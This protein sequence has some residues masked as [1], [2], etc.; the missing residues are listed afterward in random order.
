[1]SASAARFV[2]VTLWTLSLAL[3]AA[4]LVF[5]V[6][7][8]RDPS[9][10]L[11]VFGFATVGLLLASRRPDNAIGWIFSAVGFGIALGWLAAEYAARAL[12]ERPGSLPGGLWLVWLSEAVLTPTF[13]LASVL[14]LLLF[15]DG[16]PPSP[17]WRVA[18]WAAILI[19]VAFTVGIAFRPGEFFSEPFTSFENPIG[20]HLG[21]LFEALAEALWA[22]NLIGLVV[23][24]ASQIVRFRRAGPEQRAQIKWVTTV[25]LF[26]V[27]AILASNF[28]YDEGIAEDVTAVIAFVAVAGI[29]V[30]TGIAIFKY[31]LY[32]I[33]LIIRR[34]LVYGVLTAGLAGLYLG[35]VLGLQQVFS[36]FTG[37]SD[38]AIAGS[39]LAVAALFRP[40]RR[41]IQALVDRRFFR[42]KYDAQRTL[43]GFSARLR[44]E[45]DLDALGAELRGVVHRTMQPAHVSLWLRVQDGGR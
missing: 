8:G 5:S 15:P 37:G 31:H 2:S 29:P 39:T 1:V 28:A 34:T 41:H 30:A 16:R 33:D 38:L 24:A 44:D 4:G 21:G 32:D 14:L 6:L 23:A 3:G 11:L 35:I 13:F 17:R 18:V 22:A 27:G 7:N 26:A 45:I 36:S 9:I 43:E 25:G 10:V 42:R 20:I 12:V 19:A 40:A